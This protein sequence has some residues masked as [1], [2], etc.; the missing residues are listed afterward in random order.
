MAYLC[1]TSGEYG[2]CQRTLGAICVATFHT[3]IRK[4]VIINKCLNQNFQ[5]QK[6]KQDEV[7]IREVRWSGD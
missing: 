4:V 5:D 7:F 1:L 6:D 3:N 2:L